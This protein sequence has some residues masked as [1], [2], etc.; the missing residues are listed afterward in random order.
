MKMCILQSLISHLIIRT[1]C[2]VMGLESTGEPY[3]LTPFPDFDCLFGYTRETI[4]QAV[5]SGSN[6][7]LL[8]APSEPN[9]CPLKDSSHIRGTLFTES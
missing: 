2:A 7:H 4:S 5:L 1:V 8:V 3:F 6:H 9:I